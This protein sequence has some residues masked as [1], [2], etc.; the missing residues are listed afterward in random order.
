MKR[1]GAIG[2]GMLLFVVGCG[3]GAEGDTGR[4]PTNDAAL[5]TVASA[6]MPG[7]PEVLATE[8]EIDAAQLR[9]EKEGR[10]GLLIGK[11][12]EV[13]AT[14]DLPDVGQVNFLRDPGGMITVQQTHRVGALP[15]VTRED[16]ERGLAK[17][18]ERLAPERVVPAALR[19]R[20]LRHDKAG[21]EQAADPRKLDFAGPDVVDRPAELDTFTPSTTVEG[22]LQQAVVD[23]SKCP[24][25][26]WSEKM[27]H[28]SSQVCLVQRTG[29][30]KI[31]ET[32]TKFM[33]FAVCSYRGNVTQR[34]D[35]RHWSDWSI[36][37][38]VTVAPGFNTEI[39][40]YNE[41]TPFDFDFEAI[42]QEAAGDGYHQKVFWAK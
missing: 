28:S 24:A 40:G 17:A 30:S 42:V 15:P 34:I 18:F 11:D 2:L 4:D 13:L 36:H 1:I 5:E 19:E 14:I 7:A 20:D 25:T 38:R 39:F 35:Y 29:D 27:C 6:A 33:N 37:K 32:D 22:Q 9:N 31:P 23:D 10:L 12:V 26:K 21:L 41:G 8:A 16:F 3:A